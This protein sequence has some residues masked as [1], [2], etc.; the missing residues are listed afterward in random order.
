[1]RNHKCGSVVIRFRKHKYA[2][3]KL[4][5]YPLNK[6]GSGYWSNK[7]LRNIKNER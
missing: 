2:K 6:W 1:M 5:T 4:E 7:H 3:L